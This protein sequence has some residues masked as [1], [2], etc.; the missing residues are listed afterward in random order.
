MDL[1]RGSRKHQASRLMTA[2]AE[3]LVRIGSTAYGGSSPHPPGTVALPAGELDRYAIAALEAAG[4][5]EIGS[6][7]WTSIESQFLDELLSTAQTA[8]PWATVGA[9]CVAANFVTGEEPNQR[10]L[11]IVDKA[12]E[13]LRRDGVAYAQIPQFALDRWTQAHG[14]DGVR[15]AGWPSALD[16]VEIPKVGQ[17]PHVCR[18]DPFAC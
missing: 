6:P 7:A 16:Y 9:F 3:D 8:G 17:E 10:Y 18:R 2:S 1:F 15:P 5:P 4:Y 14:W 12:C 11:E 13:T